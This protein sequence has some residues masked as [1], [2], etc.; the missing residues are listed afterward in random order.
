MSKR[1]ITTANPIIALLLAL[2]LVSTFSS[3]EYLVVKYSQYVHQLVAQLPHSFF[4]SLLKN[5]APENWVDEC[6]E[7]EPKTIVK[8]H[9]ILTGAATK[10]HYVRFTFLCNLASPRDIIICLICMRIQKHSLNNFSY[11]L[12]VLIKGD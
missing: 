7:R 10:Q 11:F 8:T 9:K 6:G 4:F 5:D 2:F 3:E 1:K 12:E